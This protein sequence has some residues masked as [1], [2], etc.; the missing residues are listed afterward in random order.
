MTNKKKDF[1]MFHQP[2]NPNN[3][4]SSQPIPVGSRKNNMSISYGKVT[5]GKFL[6]STINIST[7]SLYLVSS[8]LPLA[9]GNKKGFDPF[10]L[11]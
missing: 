2:Y 7:C 1:K 3:K 11:N 9:K 4:T 10:E 8:F 5:L 6:T